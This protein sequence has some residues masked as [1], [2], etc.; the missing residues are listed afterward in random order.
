MNKPIIVHS[1]PYNND[2]CGGIRVHYQLSELERRIGY[3]SIIVYPKIPN[4][5][6]FEHNCS[7]FTIE[8]ANNYL[9]SKDAKAFAVIGYEDP[10]SL[11][12]LSEAP[13]HKI[14]YIQGHAFYRGE[15]A[16]KGA[17][18][19][20]NSNFVK[21]YCKIQGPVVP[22]FVAQAF[23]N[24]HLPHWQYH[25]GRYS[26]L[27]QDRKQG[28][29]KIDK[30]L[31]YLPSVI[32]ERLDVNIHKDSDEETF[33]NILYKSNMF[34]AHSYPEGFNL[35]PLESMAV[36]TLVVGYTGGGG[37][38]FMKDNFNCFL[39]SDGDAEKVAKIIENVVTWKYHNLGDIQRNARRTSYMYNT[40]ST[41]NHLQDALGDLYE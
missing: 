33:S 18:L 34:F 40:M 25:K 23:T 15:E 39:A 12:I 30:V 19:W 5:D 14:A 6:W 36:G 2:V 37:S 20:T 17:L 9:K 41:Q 38:D 35:T 24:Y 21:Q 29:E 1:L 11:D 4:T 26:I 27:V 8:A 22:P 3:K 7:E 32:K 16:Y 28:K 13:R 10:A 31:S